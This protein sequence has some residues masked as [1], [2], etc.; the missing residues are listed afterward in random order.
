[1]FTNFSP[2]Y[3]LI[4]QKKKSEST[5]CSASIAHKHI[6]NSIVDSMLR[7][8]VLSLVRCHSNVAK[9]SFKSSSVVSAPVLLDKVSRSTV[10]PQLSEGGWKMV[11]G[12]DAIKKNYVFTDFVEAFDF[13]T[14]VAVEAEKVNHHPEWFNVYN[15]VDVT[16][17]THDCGGLSQLD[18]NM[19]RKMDELSQKKK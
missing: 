12:R 2:T 8:G 15:R 6:F 4:V 16:L 10:L 13:M 14:R 3:L 17:A 1:M 7:S 5:L 19:A 9:R 18:V 11:D